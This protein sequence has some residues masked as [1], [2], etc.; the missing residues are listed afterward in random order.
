MCQGM[1]RMH[2]FRFKFSECT[3]TKTLFNF[4]VFLYSAFDVRQ[5]TKWQETMVL[6]YRKTNSGDTWPVDMLCMHRFVWPFTL[7]DNGVMF[8][9]RYSVPQSEFTLLFWKW[10]HLS[11]WMHSSEK[12]WICVVN[13][14]EKWIHVEYDTFTWQMDCSYN[15]VP[16]LT[17]SNWPWEYHNV[18]TNSL[19]V[20]WTFPRAVCAIGQPFP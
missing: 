6:V 11:S 18:Q 7:W 13:C 1:S 14:F 12:L 10:G 20:R 5:A 3:K 16:N 4:D 9:Q 15:V 17:W 19:N 2:W 8:W